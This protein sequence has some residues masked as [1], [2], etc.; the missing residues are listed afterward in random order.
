MKDIDLFKALDKVLEK[1]GEWNALDDKRILKQEFFVKYLLPT[2]G[3]IQ[4]NA[5]WEKL[6]KDKF[7]I[8]VRTTNATLTEAYI[9][10][11]ALLLLQQGG[12]AG[13]LKREN[14]E[15]RLNKTIATCVMIGTLGAMVFAGISAWSGCHN[16]KA[17]VIQAP[18]KRDSLLTH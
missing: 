9:S 13:K 17:S 4:A 11:E 15:K 6:K 16:E 12:Y 3:K 2:F 1:L 14:S 7:I 18:I 5:I 8:E 10:F